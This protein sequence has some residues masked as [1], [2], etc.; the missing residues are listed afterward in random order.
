MEDCA[1]FLSR[2]GCRTKLEYRV[3]DLEVVKLWEKSSD[4]LVEITF[5][6]D[7]TVLRQQLLEPEDADVE[8]RVKQELQSASLNAV[9]EKPY[10]DIRLKK[11]CPNCGSETLVRCS[12]SVSGDALPVVPIYLCK[13]CKKKSYH[14]NTSYLDYLVKGNTGLFEK[15]ELSELERDHDAFITELEGYILRIF[16]SKKITRIR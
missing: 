7:G 10:E 6:R 2:D 14:L 5:D 1:A 9:K 15:N 13:S 4:G 12:R 16:A 11:P 3:N 8:K